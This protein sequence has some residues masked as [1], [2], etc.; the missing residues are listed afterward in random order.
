MVQRTCYARR[1]PGKLLVIATPLGHL[2]DLS[3]RARE[4]LAQADC[5]AC[6]DTRRTGPLLKRLEIDTPQVA[7]HKFN[8]H[9]RLAPLLER[10]EAGETIALVSDAGTPAIS[11]PGAALVRAALDAGHAV[12][13]IPGPSAVTA[14]LSVAGFDSAGFTFEGFLPHRGGE[15]R[16]RLREIRAEDRPLVLYEAPHRIREA[17]TDIAALFGDRRIVLGRELTKIHEEL[18]VGSAE[19]LLERLAEK[20]RGEFVLAIDR[21]DRDAATLVDDG[22]EQLRVIWREELETASGNRR[23]AL[24]A[25]TRRS[26]IKRAELTRQLREIGETVDG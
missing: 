25:T 6:E 15:R 17:L 26:G 8:E 2:D 5:V 19:Q 12:S 14:L 18:L 24:K 22:A 23:Q 3:P 11:D 7:Y 20:P 1:V 21:F 10:L 16:R 13:P 9:Q 4:A